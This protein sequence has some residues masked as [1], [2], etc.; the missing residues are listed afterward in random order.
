M[1][2][3]AGQTWSAEEALDWLDDAYRKQQQI[4]VVRNNQSINLPQP[5]GAAATAAPANTN[6]NKPS[7][8]SSDPLGQQIDAIEKIPTH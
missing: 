8:S 1:G 4:I 3:V 5:A 2:K 6:T 7:K